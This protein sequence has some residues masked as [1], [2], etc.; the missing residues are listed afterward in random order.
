[1]R[2]LNTVAACASLFACNYWRDDLTLATLHL[3]SEPL[4]QQRSLDVLI[5][6]V[7]VVFVPLPR[8]AFRY[9]SL[10]SSARE[11][12]ARVLVFKHATAVCRLV[13]MLSAEREKS[14]EEVL[15]V[16]WPLIN[17]LEGVRGGLARG[18]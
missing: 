4:R 18:S 16:F 15:F 1:M 9:L 10:V 11:G 7:C 5:L 17:G 12:R 13:C 2:N 14:S 6:Y 8:D 3:Y